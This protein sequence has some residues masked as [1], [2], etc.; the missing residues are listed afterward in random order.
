[1]STTGSR[2]S[3][4]FFLVVLVALFFGLIVPIA[5]AA[6]ASEFSTLPQVSID[7]SLPTVGDEL[8]AVL[9]TATIPAAD[10]YSY[11]WYTV[12]QYFQVV[13]ISG[14][15]DQKYTATASD[16]GR[17]LEV[18]VKASKAGYNDEVDISDQTGVVNYAFTSSPEVSIDDTTPKV[19]QIVTAVLDKASV[20]AAAYDFQW[21]VDDGVH[22]L[23]G[24]GG[25][26]DA[27][28]IVENGKA[29][30]PL[31]VRI[32]AYK[33]GYYNAYGWSGRTAPV[34]KGDFTAAPIPAIND[35]T[36]TVGFPLHL[37]ISP[38]SPAGDSYAPQWKA[39]GVA[40]AGEN[41]YTFTPTLTQAGKLITVSVT[42]SK[43][44]YNDGPEIT[45]ASTDAVSVPLSGFTRAATANLNT[46]NPQ[47]GSL[48]RVIPTDASPTPD[49]YTYQW[50]RLNTFGVS[51]AIAG[52]NSQAYRV[53]DADLTRRL[54]VEVTSVKNGYESIQSPSVKTAQVNKITV[55]K[56]LIEH[57]QTLT[58][59]AK[60]LRAGQKY[61]I[62]VGTKWVYSGMV[63]STG[64]VKR[65]VLVP[66]PTGSRTVR[67]S[68]Y[69]YAGARDFTVF[70]TISVR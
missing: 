31:R 14:A 9:D 60:K 61:R 62:F 37:N 69:N 64:T 5:P 66:S 70:T 11:Q 43:Y 32:T 48:L 15:T 68:G 35:M 20:P 30:Y 59:T 33:A 63:G 36:P 4:R 17:K 45:S 53:V 41:S 39:D 8:S 40:I 3:R 22:E 42:A 50:F 47:V 24:I 10:A 55:S 29:G 44:G 1:M 34:E 13:A 23:M 26:T 46:T 51:A 2:S 56:T 25:A 52:A 54:S 21:Y 16:V 12:D 49:S 58:V 19:G 28:Y 7:I 38:S 18:I 27:T 57:G 6:A 67:V 65:E